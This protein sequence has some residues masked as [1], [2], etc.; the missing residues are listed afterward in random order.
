MS[1]YELDPKKMQR[2]QELMDEQCEWERRR[3]EEKIKELD[4]RAD[5]VLEKWKKK[6]VEKRRPKR[7][8]DIVDEDVVVDP[9]AGSYEVIPH[10]PGGSGTYL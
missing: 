1:F 4:R 3:K 8:R 10:C 2:E 6:Q 9:G 5:E 7:P